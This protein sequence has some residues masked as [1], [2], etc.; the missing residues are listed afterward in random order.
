MWN[1]PTEK[2]LSKIPKLYETENTPLKDKIIHMHFF[3]GNCDW[4]IAEYD[5]E[6]LF[7]GFAILNGWNDSAEW[8]YICLS[9]LKELKIPPGFE[10][11][12]DTF[13]EKT[14]ASDIEKIC[15]CPMAF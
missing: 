12:R 1:V 13:W 8:G 4:Y 2:Q 10:V 7:Y 14:K 15:N 11:D 9:E 6:D 5:G 3:V